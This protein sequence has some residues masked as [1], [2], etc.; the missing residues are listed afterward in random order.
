MKFIAFKFLLGLIFLI[1]IINNSLI[2]KRIKGD[3]TVT[4]EK[5]AAQDAI[6][7]PTLTNLNK[8][9]RAKFPIDPRQ[10]FKQIITKKAQKK[11]AKSMM[12]IS[13]NPETIKKYQTEYDQY[14]EQIKQLRL[15]LNISTPNDVRRRYLRR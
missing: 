9:I 13:K 8:R 14:K 15:K 10:I 4:N 1:N 5:A 6:S 2:T 7:S 12:L 3:N 11:A